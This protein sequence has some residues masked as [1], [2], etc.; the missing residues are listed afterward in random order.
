MVTKPRLGELSPY[1]TFPEVPEIVIELVD[2]PTEL[3]VGRRRTLERRGSRHQ[4][5]TG[6]LRR[7]RRAPS[8]SAIYPM[9]QK[10]EGSLSKV[11]LSFIN[12]GKGL[13]NRHDEDAT[14]RAPVRF[15]AKTRGLPGGAE[16][17]RTFDLRGAGTAAVWEAVRGS[18]SDFDILRASG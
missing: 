16:G 2:R 3:A 14:R 8:L 15:H 11:D 5:R 1:L 10:V 9:R 17:I 13:P 12:D 6:R 7:L 18:G 4:S